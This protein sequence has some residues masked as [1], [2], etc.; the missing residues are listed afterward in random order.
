MRFADKTWYR[1][2]IQGIKLAIKIEIL[3]KLKPKGLILKD[4]FEKK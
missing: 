2:L 4:L 3:K 1:D